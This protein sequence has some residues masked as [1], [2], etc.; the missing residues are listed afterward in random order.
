L[1][2]KNRTLNKEL[3]E[4]ER[5]LGEEFSEENFARLRELRGQLS[6][7]DG[8]EASIEGFGASSGRLT[9]GL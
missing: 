3:K 8:T 7:L 5:S 1:H 2:R 9:R 4:A 6:A